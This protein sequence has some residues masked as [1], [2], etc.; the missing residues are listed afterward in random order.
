LAEKKVNL[1]ICKP[2]IYIFTI[3][4]MKLIGLSICTRPTTPP[5]VPETAVLTVADE[6]DL[7]SVTFFG[8]GD[9]KKLIQFGFFFF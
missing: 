8:R 2:G 4:D 9:T 6:F 7:S 3:T 1:F 5:Q